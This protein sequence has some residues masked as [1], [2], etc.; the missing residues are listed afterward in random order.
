MWPLEMKRNLHILST[1]DCNNGGRNDH[2]RASPIYFVALMSLVSLHLNVRICSWCVSRFPPRRRL[3]GVPITLLHLRGRRPRRPRTLGRPWVGACTTCTSLLDRPTTDARGLPKHGSWIGHYEIFLCRA[4]KGVRINSGRFVTTTGVYGS[5]PGDRRGRRTNSL[6]T[7]CKNVYPYRKEANSKRKKKG[8]QTSPS[9][10]IDGK[11][12]RCRSDRAA[13][14]HRLP[15]PLPV[16]RAPRLPSCPPRYTG[17]RRH[18]ARC[19]M[20]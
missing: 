4:N 20:R 16:V 12:A 6:P 2:V 15:P 8:A 10:P 13:G 19:A 9:T 14:T 1:F 7:A 3:V 5:L 11:A 17:R 18:R